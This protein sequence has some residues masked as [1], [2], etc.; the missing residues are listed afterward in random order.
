MN[1][2]AGEV[3]VAYDLHPLQYLDLVVTDAAGRVR[4]VGHYGGIF[5]A[6]GGVQELRLGSGESFRHTVGLLTTVPRPSEA[7]RYAILARFEYGGW[8]AESGGV[9]IDATARAG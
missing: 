4:S 5:S 7:G 1:T 8:R 2:S 6:F 9:E 3:V